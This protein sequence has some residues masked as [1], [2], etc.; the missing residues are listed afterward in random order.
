MPSR[1]SPMLAQA[2]EGPF[3]SDRHL[4]EVK[5]DGTRC[6]AFIERDKLRLQNRRF[7]AMNQRYPELKGLRKLPSGTI[8]DGEIV[9]LE[10][11]KPS[12]RRLQYREHLLDANR[13]EILSHRLPATLVVFDLLYSRGQSLIA[14]RLVERR[15]RLKELLDRLVDPHIITSDYVVKYGKQYFTSA[16]RLGFEGIM[17]KRL[18]SP[19]LVGR[20][21]PHWLKIK[22]AHTAEFEIIGYIPRQGAK[23]ISALLLGVRHGRSWIYKGKVGSGFT[24]GRRQQFFEELVDAPKLSRPPKDGP[25]DAVWQS[26][27]SQCRVRFFEKTGTGKLR[28]PVFV[29]KVSVNL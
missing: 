29:G 19:Y 16:E 13:I 10:E 2:A 21:S 6:V 25:V 1:I 15:E 14:T 8:L 22:V 28:S 3:D 11:G 5:W 26:R 18:D 9:V 12:F 27:G 24:E 7:I 17:A 23:T 4:F 20:R